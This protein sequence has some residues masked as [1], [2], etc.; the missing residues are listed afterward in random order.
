MLMLPRWIVGVL[1]Q[2][3]SS[4][5]CTLGLVVQKWATQRKDFARA[6][7]VFGFVLFLGGQ[8]LMPA[9]LTMA[10][11]SVLSCLAPTTLLFNSVLTP[12]ILGEQFTAYHGASIVCI[13]VGCF[14]T[15]QF[16]MHPSNEKAEREGQLTLSEVIHLGTR[17]LFLVL[18]AA[19]TVAAAC[20]AKPVL[21][22]KF[23]GVPA[24][25]SPSAAAYANGGCDD[26][27]EQ[28]HRVGGNRDVST[29]CSPA[30]RAGNTTSSPSLARALEK[31]VTAFQLM[32]LSTI[33]GAISVTNTK[34]V[35]TLFADD[36]LLHQSSGSSAPASEGAS[37]ASPPLTVTTA[38]DEHNG[39][40]SPLAWL[41]W[42]ETGL[43]CLILIL[44]GIIGVAV[45]SISLLNLSLVLFSSLTTV[46]LDCALGLVMQLLYG[47]VFFEEYKDYTAGTFFATAV[48]VAFSFG[49][50]GFLHLHGMREAEEIAE[51]DLCSLPS[52]A[53]LP[54]LVEVEED[55]EQIR[56]INAGTS[57]A[58]GAGASSA[59]SSVVGGRRV[60]G[61]RGSRRGENFFRAYRPLAEGPP[62]AGYD[63]QNIFGKD[64]TMSMSARGQ[65]LTNTPTKSTNVPS[66][67]GSD[68][69]LWRVE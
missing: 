2:N 53:S 33:F 35:S 11:Q 25:T 45:I 41:F 34:I 21:D 22:W 69:D 10:P 49:G 56:D 58:I 27:L 63:S 16:G 19:S 65:K 39:P 26:A 4:F 44:V 64:S 23:G 61:G 31:R 30:R 14:I 15:V 38:T 68:E 17:P 40:K 66:A 46:T 7:W 29:P 8:L 9:A 24:P 48:G 51:A 42:T 6:V 52:E 36:Y 28:G 50:L 47:A 60:G 59:L 3:A 43:A 12:C 62:E 57:L 20:V 5:T 1:L 55:G 13:F 37:T 67:S 54:G 32:L 18:V